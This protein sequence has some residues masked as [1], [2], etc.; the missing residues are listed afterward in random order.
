MAG[1]TRRESGEY[2]VTINET[3]ASPCSTYQVSE[4]TKRR[5]RGREE[6]RDREG[7]RERE[8]D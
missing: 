6:E 7:K 2:P 3:I 4:G 1:E 5:R 8:R